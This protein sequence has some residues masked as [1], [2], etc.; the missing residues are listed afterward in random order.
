[1]YNFGS[2]YR[3]VCL[4]SIYYSETTQVDDCFLT[5][6]LPHFKAKK[7]AGFRKANSTSIYV[8]LVQEQAKTCTFSQ[9]IFTGEGH[10]HRTNQ[11]SKKS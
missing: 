5:A 1:M 11:E 10:H 8:T 6:F 7:K 4:L 2:W 9:Q 3:L